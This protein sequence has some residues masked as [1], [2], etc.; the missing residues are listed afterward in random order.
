MDTTEHPSYEQAR[1]K[2][3]AELDRRDKEIR[4]DQLAL[5]RKKA[6][7]E[8]VQASWERMS[9]II[10][11]TGPGAQ[12][13]PAPKSEDPGVYE[14]RINWYERLR[15]DERIVV[16]TLTDIGKFTVNRQIEERVMDPIVK[17][18]LARITLRLR[19]KH[20][21]LAHPRSN[22]NLKTHFPI[23]LLTWVDDEGRVRPERE[24]EHIDKL[25]ALKHQAAATTATAQ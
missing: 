19:E 21:L 23:G 22:P 25:V 15:P 11:G 1:A 12:P 6:E 24:Y 5:D 16:D 13:E 7:R 20:I 2:V 3:Q 9:R 4:A 8:V 18:N 17:K 10:Y 14:L